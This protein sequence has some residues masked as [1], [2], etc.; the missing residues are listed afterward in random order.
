MD[1]PFL[2]PLPPQPHPALHVKF[3]DKWLLLKDILHQLFF[4]TNLKNRDIAKYMKDNY[5]F[6]ASYAPRFQ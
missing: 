4:K 5:S 6:D 3:D 2:P 1:P